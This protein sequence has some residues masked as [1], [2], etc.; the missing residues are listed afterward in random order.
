MGPSGFI[1]V[2]A[3]WTTTEVGRQPFTVVTACC[4]TAD[5]RSPIASARCR[6]VRSCAF[7]AIY[8]AAFGVGV[9]YCLQDDACRAPSA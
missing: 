2:I 9:W 3:G 5:S 6:R 1:A 4:A 7:V 8:I